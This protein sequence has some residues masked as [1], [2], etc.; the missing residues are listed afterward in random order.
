MPEWQKYGMLSA[1][2]AVILVEQAYADGLARKDA[3]IKAL[4]A[5]VNAALDALVNAIEMDDYDDKIDARRNL[6]AIR[7]HGEEGR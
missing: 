7:A 4:D 1:E 5:L 6:E 3:E 2:S